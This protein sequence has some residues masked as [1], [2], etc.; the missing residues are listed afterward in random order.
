M[1]PEKEGSAYYL[2]IDLGGT[3][4]VAAVVDDT[5]KLYPKYRTP[6]AAHRP[7]GQVVDDLVNAA[8]QALQLAGLFP[9]DVPYVGIGVPSSI[10]PRT[11]R[12]VYANNLGW[13]DAD[14]VGEFQKRWDIPV[15]VANDAD[16]ATLGESLAGAAQAYESA[17]MVTVGTGLGGGFVSGGRL[18]LG[19]DGFGMEPG[20]SR[21][22][23]DGIRCTCGQRGC[24]ESYGSVTALIRQTI[25]AMLSCPESL[26][27]QE[28]G[29]DLN[30]VEGRTAFNAAKKGDETA[31][32]VVDTYIG[33]LGTGL[34]SLVTLF[35]PQAVI[36]GGGL[37]NEG[38]PLLEPLRR[39]IAQKMYAPDILAPPAVLQAALG[40]D[41]GVIGAALLDM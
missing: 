11:K 5:H 23:Y 14:V 15:R 24:F 41:A 31:R 7:F 3:N 12:V 34:G 38:E 8:R 22:M 2:G 30:R 36:V 33:Y 19:G 13:K 28:C 18:F 25:G 17:L 37:S 9:A 40:N 39:D 27:W 4:I 26:M 20:H 6:T 16:C 35:R 21:L 29:R 1:A 10:D 32:Q